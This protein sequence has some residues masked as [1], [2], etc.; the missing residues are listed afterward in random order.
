MNDRQ[1]ATLAVTPFEDL[2]ETEENVRRAS[3]SPAAYSNPAAA[4]VSRNRW[5]ASAPL[6]TE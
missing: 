4:P 1:C 2:G 5:I 3:R 6:L